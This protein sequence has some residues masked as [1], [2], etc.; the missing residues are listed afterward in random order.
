[1]NC[2]ECSNTRTVVVNKS[3]RNGKML[4]LYSCP[5]CKIRFQT[6]EILRAQPDDET[7]E[8]NLKANRR[9]YG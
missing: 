1:M 7:I 5:S 4:R 6:K 3:K 9:K 2:P 8:F